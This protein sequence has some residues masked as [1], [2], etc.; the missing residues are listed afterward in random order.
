MISTR[1]MDMAVDK[2]GIDYHRSA[3][4]LTPGASYGHV[5][6]FA[7]KFQIKTT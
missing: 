2:S 1:E 5:S 6:I 3:L 7:Q 4:L